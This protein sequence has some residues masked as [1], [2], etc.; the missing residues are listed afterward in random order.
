MQVI[1]D[2]DGVLLNWKTA[3][4]D[5]MIENTFFRGFDSWP[6][7]SYDFHVFAQL[8]DGSAFPKALEKP[9][10]NIFN[11]THHIKKL[12]PIP[13]AVKAV[14][15]L[16]E[17]G[18]V[19]KVVTSFSDK[20]ESMRMREKNL[21]DVFGHVFQDIVGLPLRESKLNYL[22][23]QDINSVFVDDL[24]QHITSA[25]EAGLHPHNIFMVAHPYNA[26]YEIPNFPVWNRCGW[27][28]I[29]RELS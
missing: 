17:A 12:P 28:S 21:I 19:I 1:L 13:G 25:L 11:E 4:I 3:F 29:I 2:C 23:K 10:M 8:P 16:H 24:P 15:K 5:W 20:Y 14:Q 7:E 6:E 27:S 9:L 18:A 22:S 26:G